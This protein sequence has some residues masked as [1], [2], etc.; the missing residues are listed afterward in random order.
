MLK[1][2]IPLYDGQCETPFNGVEGVVKIKHDFVCAE[3]SI[4]G[5]FMKINCGADDLLAT[6]STDKTSIVSPELYNHPHCTNYGVNS[7]DPF[8][9]PSMDRMWIDTCIPFY[10]VDKTS[11]KLIHI[12]NFQ[13]KVQSLQPTLQLTKSN[14]LKTDMSC[15]HVVVEKK[16]LIY[17][18]VLLICLFLLV[19]YQI[20]CFM[21]NFISIVL[22]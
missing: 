8:E 14:Y 16:V 20:P 13:L 19:A 6:F 22:Q 9:V 5:G 7:E 12:F 3:D 11:G 18:A 10:D 1:K 15:Q 21:V 17:R 4:K 2:K